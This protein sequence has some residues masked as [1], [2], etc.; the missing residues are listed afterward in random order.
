MNS[1]R[2]SCCYMISNATVRSTANL[3]LNANSASLK[4]GVATYIFLRLTLGVS[5]RL[6][7]AALEEGSEIEQRILV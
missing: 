1:E 6:V 7:G 3:A 2:G 5:D 4:G